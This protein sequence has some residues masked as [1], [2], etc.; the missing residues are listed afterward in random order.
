MEEAWYINTWGGVLRYLPQFRASNVG[1]GVYR[2]VYKGD[3]IC[4]FERKQANRIKSWPQ[5]S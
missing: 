2:P 4:Y 1:F 3:V 5:F